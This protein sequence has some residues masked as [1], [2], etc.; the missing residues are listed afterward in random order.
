MASRPWDELEYSSSYQSEVIVTQ[1]AKQSDTSQDRAEPQEHQNAYN[2][3]NYGYVDTGDN[4]KLGFLILGDW[5]HLAQGVLKH[6]EGCGQGRSVALGKSLNKSATTG[7]IVGMFGNCRQSLECQSLS[8]E[9]AAWQ[10][11]RWRKSSTWQRSFLAKQ[12][13]PKNPS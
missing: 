4:A 12:R 9:S 3:Q 8:A 6:E 5:L 7:R 11:L 2:V 13:I 10:T 1:Y